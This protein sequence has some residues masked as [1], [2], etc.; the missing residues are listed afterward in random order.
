MLAP[1]AQ[2]TDHGQIGGEAMDGNLH[3]LT[4][5]GAEKRKPRPRQ[6]DP[7]PARNPVERPERLRKLAPWLL[8]GMAGIPH[9][10]DV[11]EAIYIEAVRLPKPVHPEEGEHR[12]EGDQV[13]QE[14]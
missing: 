9:A 12:T 7:G 1:E 14:N 5:L 8:L 3:H 6:H 10:S 2:H 13:D 11:G 4:C